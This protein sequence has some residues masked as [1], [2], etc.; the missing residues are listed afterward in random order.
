MAVEKRGGT[1]KKIKN[2]HI[3][4]HKGALAVSAVRVALDEAEAFARAAQSL[5]PS[6]LAQALVAEA[7]A[8]RE[9]LGSPREVPTGLL[10]RVQM[11][12]GSAKTELG[13]AGPTAAPMVARR[14]AAQISRMVAEDD[15]ISEFRE[16]LNATPTSHP[17]KRVVDQWLEKIERL[18]REGSVRGLVDLL[19]E[20][21]EW[22]RDKAPH[23]IEAHR[24]SLSEHFEPGVDVGEA[25]SVFA[26][27]TSAYSPTEKESIV[28][29]CAE[30]LAAIDALAPSILS[31]FRTGAWDRIR[32]F[33]S[34]QLPDGGPGCDRSA[35]HGHTVRELTAVYQC[36][37][38]RYKAG[39]IE[40]RAYSGTSRDVAIVHVALHEL[41]HALHLRNERARR[42]EPEYKRAMDAVT[43]RFDEYA[44]RV[45][46]LRERR[47]KL[48]GYDA[49]AATSVKEFFAGVTQVLAGHSAMFERLRGFVEL[50][51]E[52]RA[53]VLVVLNATEPDEPGWCT[54]S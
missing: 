40:V 16:I 18:E 39:S 32:V 29:F 43:A 45:R 7:R 5:A 3:K 52:L 15:R 44:T 31:P 26:N 12:E 22:S 19:D 36:P 33:V 54:L 4:I 8:I 24:A 46:E 49:Y 42:A 50:R 21:A 37:P 47:E 14:L 10:P 38:H 17:E 51:P 9:A 34:R 27:R 48:T 2:K 25:L 53:H 35:V 41:I 28:K 30:A 23:A 6:G 20:V 1:K 11:V 13:V